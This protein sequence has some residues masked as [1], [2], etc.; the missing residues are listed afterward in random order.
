MATTTAHEADMSVLQAI[1]LGL[2]Q[3]VTEFIP[4]SSS[5]HLIL[6][7]WL[8]NWHFLLDNPDLNKTF[9]VALHLGTFFAVLVYFWRDIGHLLAAF[10]RSLRR[11]RAESTDERLAWLLLISTI[12]AGVVG[13]AFENFIE[14]RL[15]KP[16]LIAALMIV[17]GLVMWYVDRHARLEREMSALTRGGA[18]G[19]G[20]AQALALAPGVSRSGI[21]MVTGMLLGLKREAAARYSFLLSVPVIGGAAFYKALKIAADGLPAGTTRALRGRHRVRHCQRLRGRVVHDGLPSPPQLRPVRDL[22]PGGRPRRARADRRRR[23]LGYRRLGR[24][25]PARAGRGGPL[26]ILQTA[27]DRGVSPRARSLAR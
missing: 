25:P 17:F 23:A 11:R 18:L 15:G 8:F 27:I 19:I 4:I 12:P 7:P 10:F 22:P 13:V 26:A 20:V 1:I 5:G 21:T 6:V 9:D 3:G 24:E 2:V 16:V 14:D